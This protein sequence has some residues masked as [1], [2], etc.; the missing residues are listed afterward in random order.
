M[1]SLTL[2]WTCLYLTKNIVYVSMACGKVFTLKT[3]GSQNRSCYM[4][5]KVH[6]D[7]S[8]SLTLVYEDR[9][10]RVSTNQQGE[11]V[12]EDAQ[13]KVRMRIRPYPQFFVGVG[14]GL[15]FVTD[16]RVE[17]IPAHHLGIVWCVIPRH[18]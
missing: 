6:P 1:D 17:P 4:G 15:Q 2:I 10:I 9:D 7:D 5:A 13:S 12:V 8:Q 14:G 11:L 16:G 3:I 18:I